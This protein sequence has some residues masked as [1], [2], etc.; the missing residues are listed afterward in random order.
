MEEKT[1]K[2][3]G[4]K[5][6]D[7][8]SLTISKGKEYPR[9]LEYQTGFYIG[10][11]WDR[12]TARETPRKRTLEL[13]DKL[14]GNEISDTLFLEMVRQINLENILGI[15]ILEKYTGAKKIH[16]QKKYASDCKGD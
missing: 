15:K 4:V 16:Y 2:E 14:T 6:G 3:L 13:A 8:I 12:D 9:S 11:E 7:T 1:I 10:I 5:K